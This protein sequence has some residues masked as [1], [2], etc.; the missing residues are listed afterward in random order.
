[1]NATFYIPILLID[2]NLHI[3]YHVDSDKLI[4]IC[5]YNQ[6][7]SPLNLADGCNNC[8]IPGEFSAA[9]AWR[10]IFGCSTGLANCAELINDDRCCKFVP[11]PSENGNGNEVVGGNGWSIASG[12]GGCLAVEV[13]A[14]DV[15]GGEF[16]V[17]VDTPI[18]VEVQGA[19]VWEVVVLSFDILFSVIVFVVWWTGDIFLRE[20]SKSP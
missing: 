1:M 2:L 18:M 8:P 3:L 9:S 13:E 12:N 20:L 16:S 17:F 10:L 15:M 7:S 5:Y 6:M 19:V 11:F 14:T 4:N